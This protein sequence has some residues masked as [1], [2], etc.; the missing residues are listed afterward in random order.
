MDKFE[1]GGWVWSAAFSPDGERL[2]TAS[3]DGYAR[4]L[5]VGAQ[6]K[7]SELHKFKHGNG[8][9]SAAFSPD[10]ERLVTGSY[11][12]YIWIFSDQTFIIKD[13]KTVVSLDTGQEISRVDLPEI[14]KVMEI[15]NRPWPQTVKQQ[16]MEFASAVSDKDRETARRRLNA[17]LSKN[18]A[19]LSWEQRETADLEDY[20]IGEALALQGISQKHGYGVWSA[21]FSPDGERLVTASDDG[22][23]RVFE[24]GEQGKLREL[25]KFE[26]GGGVW[27]AAFS[28]DGERLVTGS[29]D[30]YA[31]VFA[32]GAQGKLSELAKFKHEKG[33]DFAA[34]SPDGKRLATASRDGYARILSHQ[35]FIIKDEK[36]A[37]FLDSGKDIARLDLPLTLKALQLPRSQREESAPVLERF[38]PR[39]GSKPFYF[40]VDGKGVVYLN[41]KGKLMRTR[42]ELMPGKRFAVSAG[43]A[44]IAL[45]D[46]VNPYTS[47]GAALSERDFLMDTEV[48]ESVEQSVLQA[49]R[50]GWS[51][52]LEGAPGG[53]K[54]SISREAALL[55]GLPRYV[56]QMH[57]QRE[58]QDLIGSYREDRDGKIH[59]TATP[60]RDAQGRIRF[61]LPL[62]DFLVNGGVYV[63]DE[64]AIG[65]QG[66]SI[67]SWFS[68]IAHRDKEIVIHEFPGREMRLPLSED[69]HLL[70]T[71][72]LPEETADR[73]H[74][75]SEIGANV[76]VIHV[77]EDES[78]ET[79]ERLFS[80]FL[81]PLKDAAGLGKILA[82]FHHTL[83]PMIGNELGR[84]GKDRYYISKR[85]IRRVADLVKA[86]GAADGYALCKAMRMVYE[87]MFT[88]ADERSKVL[89][90]IE[91][92]FKHTAQGERLSP[93]AIAAHLL[94]NGDP[95]LLISEPGA[96]TSDIVGLAAKANNARVE[97]IDAV[98]EHTDH[99]ILG[100]L[101]PILG[102]RQEG[103][104]RAK[105]VKGALSKYL[106]AQR[107]ASLKDPVLLWIRNIDQWPEDLRTAINGLLEDG[108][109]DLEDDDGMTR[110][111]Y[112]PRGLY[113]AAEMPADS[114]EEFS[115]AFFNRW[116]KI[117]VSQ[118]TAEDLQ[119]A[120]AKAYGLDPTQARRVARLYKTIDEFDQNK[121]WAN[122]KS[123]DVGLPIFYTLAQSI[124]SADGENFE[125]NALETAA[126]AAQERVGE[127][128]GPRAPPPQAASEKIHAAIFVS[129]A[130]RILGP[131]FRPEKYRT[132]ISDAQRFEKV[133]EIIAGEKLPPDTGDALKTQDGTMNSPLTAIGAVAV[134]TRGRGLSLNAAA[135][136][137]G[138]K[139]TSQVVLMLGVLARAD[140]LGKVTALIG[141][142]GAG[143]TSVAELWADLSGRRFYKYQ[144]HAGSQYGDFTIDLEQDPD[145]DFHKRIKEFYRNL[146][147]GNVVIGLDEANVAPW[148][149]WIL[150]PLLRGE[151]VIH[152]IFPEEEPFTVGQGVQVVLM[153]NPERY[154]GRNKINANL[155]KRM[156]VAW[157]GTPALNEIE[158]IIA[159]FYGVV[160][161]TAKQMMD[162]FA[163][164][165]APAAVALSARAGLWRPSGE[166]RLDEIE[167]EDESQAASAATIGFKSSAR[168][169]G[170]R[171]MRKGLET[172]DL[173]DENQAVMQNAVNAMARPKKAKEG[174][175]T[176][177]LFPYER[178][179]A[180]DVFDEGAQEF[181]VGGQALK[182]MEIPAL[183]E[184]ELLAK[185][186][187]LGKSRDFF[188]GK[189]SLR[190]S[191]DWT[192]IP[193]AGAGM[194][195]LEMAAFDSHGGQRL[196]V[197]LQAA[198]DSA[199]NV[200]VR[201]KRGAATAGEVRFVAGVPVQ[202]FA[203]P[204]PPGI[205]FHYP[206]HLAPEVAEAVKLMGLT[207]QERDLRGVAHH[208]V[209][210]FRNFTLEE[211]GIADS[212]RSLYLDLIHSQ[213]GVCRHRAYAFA[214]TALG[215]GIPARYALSDMHAWAEIK[216]PKIGWVRIDLGG[217]GDPMNMDLAPLAN[218]S[219][220]S[221]FSDGLPQPNN[222][223]ETGAKMAE[224][225]KMAMAS[226]G[227]TPAA[228]SAGGAA[229]ASAESENERIEQ[230]LQAFASSLIE[231][232]R[233]NDELATLFLA[234]KGDTEFIFQRML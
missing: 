177:E 198:K 53:G 97:P 214:R 13:E 33:V 110:R 41:F 88:H 196:D 109:V 115:S 63:L 164:G 122:H 37:V 154:S 165:L 231:D 86:A 76:Q 135:L 124:K 32:V 203:Y 7:L 207:G 173:T 84:D 211:N 4:V 156:I 186:R 104:T 105:I 162:S 31:R 111:F 108:Y 132:Q 184:R 194:E 209:A 152:P 234:G 202:Y 28:P 73:Y 77:Q 81:A 90:T 94:G 159:H 62:L 36:T 119:T 220:Q 167:F 139:V 172:F 149:L 182:L 74:L 138:L 193:A 155:V 233:I 130:R 216:I 117:G 35:T 75:K 79:L 98:P 60:R 83:K 136:K 171:L 129:E 8:F 150:E 64:G 230:A 23:A 187:A 226:Q 70:V 67:L 55:L 68:A 222:Y 47:D 229:A 206:Q 140:R 12:G 43:L 99:E 10:G 185:M 121:R 163:A 107:G 96:R 168:A 57:G 25:D 201:I 113:L 169:G 188:T 92:A 20:D 112:R 101:S 221:R 158:G 30:N 218:Q 38:T 18:A 21:A 65:A 52:N 192:A 212:G 19:Q 61:K 143:K 217:G 3:S 6:G 144:S 58:L 146:K 16:R 175:F 34:F 116:L 224:R 189:K 14:V 118:D 45:A 157:M 170:D 151:R 93:A 29:Y 179:A 56:F 228:G 100:G 195:I 123:Y 80:Y 178:S 59:L 40:M 215:L 181:A 26:H 106:S 142:T 126:R 85:E 114:T 208:L 183:N 89:A 125:L 190:L 39:Y 160:E 180:Y 219:H 5:A 95:V 166:T 87:A 66:Q 200:Y 91:K 133:L 51:V 71:N 213:A 24:L 197:E 17:V 15:E 141:E 205:D 9:Q 131:R 174:V 128:V 11:D 137:R 82:K 191:K 161:K 44:P 225:M 148:V 120:L 46:I 49:F 48:L 176:P 145:G 102:P 210:F 147:A 1:H 127:A 22:Y 204:I 134:Q 27:S 54:T 50:G 2:V 69:F 199:D 42:H 223:L 153:Y 78:E 72:N 232:V 103:Q 227:I